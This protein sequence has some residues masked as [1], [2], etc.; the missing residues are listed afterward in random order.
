MQ[1]S[2]LEGEGGG[3]PDYRP[4]EDVSFVIV[5]IA[6]EY[7]C[8]RVEIECSTQATFFSYLWARSRVSS[9]PPDSSVL[10]H[11]PAKTAGLAHGTCSISL[12]FLRIR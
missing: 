8:I 4:Y 10:L 2:L 12:R 1:N 3:P 6:E 5:Y 9:K 11:L 7:V